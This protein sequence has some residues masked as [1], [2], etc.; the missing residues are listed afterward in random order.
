MNAQIHH[1]QERAKLMAFL[2]L[3]RLTATRSRRSTASL[4]DLLALYR[5]RRQLA[6]LD[7]RALRDIGLDHLSACL[8]YTSP[9]PR[10]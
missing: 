7:T 6:R 10:D 5:E 4:R 3:P 1:E 9:S 2:T 8:L